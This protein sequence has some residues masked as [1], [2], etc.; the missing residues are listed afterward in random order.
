MNIL[1]NS[2]KNKEEVNITDDVDYAVRNKKPSKPIL[3]SWQSV[4]FVLLIIIIVASFLIIVIQTGRAANL[5][6]QNTSLKA[7][8]QAQQEENISLKATIEAL[9]P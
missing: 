9:N 6:G 1:D 5:N 3:T 7:T 8:V 2:P 4:L